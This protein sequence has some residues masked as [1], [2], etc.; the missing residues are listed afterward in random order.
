MSIALMVPDM[1]KAAD[2]LPWLHRIDA[3]RHYTNRGPLAQELEACLGCLVR[4]TDPSTV[5]ADFDATVV[6]N[7]TTALELAL[8]AQGVGPGWTVAVPALT[9]PATGLAPLRL[10]ADVVL[11]DVDPTTWAL[12]P[13]LARAA[14]AHRTIDMVVPV[15]AFGSPVD[16]AGWDAFTQET[17]VPVTVDAAAALGAQPGSRK[18]VIVF[19][20]HATKPFGVGEGGLVVGPSTVTAAVRRLANFGFE[21]GRVA[22]AGWNGKLS[23]YHAAVGLAQATRFEDVRARRARVHAGY[24]TGLAGTSIRFQRHL[25]PLIPAVLPVRF[26]SVDAADAAEAALERFGIETRRWYAPALHHHPAFE[27][28]PRVGTAGSEA[29]PTSES[30]ARHLVGLPFHSFLTPADVERVCA[31]VRAG[32]AAGTTE[33]RSTAGTLP[34][35]MVA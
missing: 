19:S 6:G 31:V 22:T 9:F 25:R 15:A 1:P 4:N 21:G 8:A 5:D 23:E 2:L 12:T 29:L 30:L 18:G 32:L 28:C 7:G 14:L 13:D 35:G 11:L 16:V 3:A 27:H 34:Q 10:G 26:P 20:L 33:Q 17:G 24:R